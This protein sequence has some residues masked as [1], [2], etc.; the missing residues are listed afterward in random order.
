MYS[1]SSPPIDKTINGRFD[2]KYGLSFV[3][4]FLF[5]Y[6][7]LSNLRLT[8]PRGFIFILYRMINLFFLEIEK[9]LNLVGKT[10][11]IPSKCRL[12]LLS[13]LDGNAN[14]IYKN[15]I[16]NTSHGSRLDNIFRWV[17]EKYAEI[18]RKWRPK[19]DPKTFIVFKEFEVKVVRRNLLSLSTREKVF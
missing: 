6:S 17:E 10:Q 4:Y 14:S 11:Q 9:E 18:L 15:L 13:S 8:C 12:S 7:I 19:N 5:K 3:W 16:R 2:K 1:E